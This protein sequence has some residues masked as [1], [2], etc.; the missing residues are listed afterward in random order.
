MRLSWTVLVAV[1]ASLVVTPQFAMAEDDVQEQLQA[2]QEHMEQLE[3]RLLATTDDL[4][5]ATK[6]ADEQ[7]E[8]LERVALTDRS[9]ASGL[10]SFLDSVD[11]SGF[12]A[13]SY[14]HSLNS[15]RN[16]A[17]AT[18]I[19]AFPGPQPGGL[20]GGNTTLPYHGGSESFSFDQLEITIER[21]ISPEQRAGFVFDMM[22]GRTASLND[23][24]GYSADAYGSV[25][26]TNEVWVSEAY[27]QY[28]APMP[29]PIGDLTLVFGRFDTVIGAEV[30]EA[31]GN[32]NITR[33]IVFNLQP[34]RHTGIYVAKDWGNGWD[35]GFGVVNS[36][37]GAGTDNNTSK[38]LVFHAG[39]A[40]DALIGDSW[41][42]SINLATGSETTGDNETNTT[43]VD[44]VLTWDYSADLQFWANINW[45]E[46]EGFT[47]PAGIR[48]P[49]DRIIG[50]AV[51]ARYNLEGLT[52]LP[53]HV[54]SRVEYVTQQEGTLMGPFAGAATNQVQAWSF[55]LTGDYQLTEKLL[56]RAEYRVDRV[57]GAMGD[58]FP[59]ANG[60]FTDKNHVFLGELIYEF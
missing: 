21:P 2:M 34:I 38:T 16:G 39:W 58:I 57:Q 22:F 23:G 33:G 55:T 25:S 47:P 29:G 35:A 9:A 30:V 3:D 11:V 44:F 46:L 28:L 26:D 17:G 8:V 59:Q 53:I 6:R 54:S 5:A 18:L 19:G 32:W 42:A 13:V 51:A 31:N 36:I 49:G 60:N 56:A 27:I 15:P 43:L 40:G 14:N 45:L 41:S 7:A 24:G 4:E 20:G 48:V 12:M 50:F 10:S 52:N 1:V 37:F